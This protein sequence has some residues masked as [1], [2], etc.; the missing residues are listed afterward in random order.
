MKM[1]PEINPR[2]GRVPG[3]DLL[4]PRIRVSS[5]GGSVSKLGKSPSVSCLGFRGV[6]VGERATREGGG[7]AH[8]GCR[9]GQRWGRGQSP[10][11]LLVAPL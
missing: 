11:G 4:N 7:G 10:H 1:A 9:R 3:Q 5:C 2:P 8:A 6:Y